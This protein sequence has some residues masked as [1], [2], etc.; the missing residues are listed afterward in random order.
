MNG[1]RDFMFLSCGLF[2][3]IT[4]GPGRLLVPVHVFAF[5]GMAVWLFWTAFYFSVAYWVAG[6]LGQRIVVYHCSAKDFVSRLVELCRELDPQT[7]LD[8][9]VLFLPDFGI[10]C[11]VNCNTLG[12]VFILTS[13][14]FCR[15][16]K[17]W[18]DFERI[19]TTKAGD[20]QGSWKVSLIFWSIFVLMLFAVT[21]WTAWELPAL[22]EE[23]FID[24]RGE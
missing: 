12:G 24:Y 22:L 13:T 23:I 3:L 18:L 1:V 15:G 5:W 17:K 2:G 8:G 6:L 7:R 4:L 20:F 10:Q 19:L 21:A 16:E 14:G 9:N 11:S